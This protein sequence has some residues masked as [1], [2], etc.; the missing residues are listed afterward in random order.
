MNE[1]IE[2]IESLEELMNSG[3]LSHDELYQKSVELDQQKTLLDEKEFR[4]LELSE[5]G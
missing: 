4:W 1:I 5:L 3:S 2:K